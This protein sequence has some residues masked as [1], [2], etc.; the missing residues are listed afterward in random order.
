MYSPG[1]PKRLEKLSLLGDSETEASFYLMAD[2]RLIQDIVL[3]IVYYLSL[4]R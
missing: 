3:E 4:A 1:K 2:G